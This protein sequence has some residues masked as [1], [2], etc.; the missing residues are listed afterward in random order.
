MSN[1]S[2]SANSGSFSP[3]DQFHSEQQ[4]IQSSLAQ[5]NAR[6]T[7]DSVAAQAISMVP[8]A[9]S[10]TSSLSPQAARMARLDAERDG[11]AVS[12]AAR[13]GE[14]KIEHADVPFDPR[15][16][17]P[18][19]PNIDHDTFDQNARALSG[20]INLAGQ[21]GAA[22]K[23]Q[24]HNVH[25]LD[26]LRQQMIEQR[27]TAQARAG[28]DSGSAQIRDVNEAVWAHGE[29]D[30]L[31]QILGDGQPAMSA[32]MSRG[33]APLS[34]ERESGPTANVVERQVPKTSVQ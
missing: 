9:D 14:A 27:Q 10:P 18:A 1:M 34:T 20:V 33:T 17:M 22:D 16:H 19:L 32:S 31:D 5:H 8:P 7:A 21:S 6:M 2:I 26:Q 28:I 4:D 23:A 11:S 13:H 15:G 24:Q 3:L 12:D 25:A 30:K 29:I